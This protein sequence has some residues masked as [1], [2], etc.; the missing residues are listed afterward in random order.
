MG[1]FLSVEIG[2]CFVSG[3]MPKLVMRLC[4]LTGM[5]TVWC[6]FDWMDITFPENLGKI[7]Y[8]NFSLFLILIWL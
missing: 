7:P 2:T 3:R 4:P 1:C 8:D 6:L 5:F